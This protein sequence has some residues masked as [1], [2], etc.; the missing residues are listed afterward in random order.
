[1]LH[2]PSF[3]KNSA[4]LALSLLSLSLIGC[5]TAANLGLIDPKPDRAVAEQVSDL[6]YPGSSDFGGDLD[7]VLEVDG[8]KLRLVNRSPKAFD[9]VELWLNK[10]YV[11][12]VNDIPVGDEL[13][14]PLR[15]FVDKHGRSYPYRT[16]LTPERGK[17]LVLGEIY[18]PK[19]GER[20]RL[21]VQLEEA[22]PF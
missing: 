10:Q 2:M 12:V 6:R 14:L 8:S 9:D 18:D 19:T 20:H 15:N 17:R 4:A 1:M 11:R 5:G 3:F 21:L 22:R 16:F 13:K 7:I